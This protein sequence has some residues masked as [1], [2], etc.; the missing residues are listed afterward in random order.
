M[1][2]TLLILSLLLFSTSVALAH[3]DTMDGPLV[4]D[5][6]LALQQNNVNIVLKWIPASDES[7]LKAAFAQTMKVRALS[8]DALQLAD[9]VFFE[10]LVRI[11]RAGEGVPFT[12]VKPSGTPIDEKIL[13]ADK[14][15][16]LGNLSPLDGLVKDSEK[17]ELAELFHHVQALKNFNVNNVEAGRKYIAAYV[18]FFK[19]AEGE[20]HHEAG[21]HSGAAVHSESA[22]HS[23]SAVC[24]S[25]PCPHKA[26]IPWV[27]TI[28]FFITTTVFASLY[29]RKKNR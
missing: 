7:E 26:H 2:T 9:K 21:V 17:A 23:D 4:K 29:Y 3:C 13:A 20:T 27:L 25:T 6:Q 22:A 1:K 19:F 15:I 5:A 11:H 16:E 10:T 28:I 14:A 8:S 12:G 18:Q 24:G